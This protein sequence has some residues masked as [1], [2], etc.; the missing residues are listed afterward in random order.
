MTKQTNTPILDQLS[1][2]GVVDIKQKDG[3]F[4]VYERSTHLFQIELT[5]QQLIQL[6][7]ELRTLAA[8]APVVPT[9]VVPTPHRRSPMRLLYPIVFGFGSG[10]LAGTLG[11]EFTQSEYW[12]I[13]APYIML[14]TYLA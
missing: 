2:G 10:V 8:P 12:L 9:P 5:S 4:L 11:F 13:S 6:S 1:V 14:G 3:A 7:D